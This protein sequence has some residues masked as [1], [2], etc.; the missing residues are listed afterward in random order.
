[1]GS[2]NPSRSMGLYKRYCT[3][4][5][6]TLNEFLTD[7]QDQTLTPDQVSRLKELYSELKD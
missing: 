6:T 4:K 7:V 5:A 2:V 3:D 1:M